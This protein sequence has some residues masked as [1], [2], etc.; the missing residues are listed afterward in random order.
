MK[1]FIAVTIALILFLSL[2][3]FW[4][5]SQGHGATAASEKKVSKIRYHKVPGLVKFRTG[6]NWYQTSK[7]H[8]EG[9]RPTPDVLLFNR[10]VPRAAIQINLEKSSFSPTTL[11]KFIKLLADQ[12]IRWRWIKQ[13]GEGSARVYFENDKK[14]KVGLL[15]VRHLPGRYSHLLIVG[16]GWSKKDHKKM[17][18]EYDKIVESIVADP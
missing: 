16:G 12:N 4:S 6:P 3:C 1:F 13:G 9:R 11:V 8:Y 15:D 18:V 7:K 17:S 10:S 14:K 5:G 2:G